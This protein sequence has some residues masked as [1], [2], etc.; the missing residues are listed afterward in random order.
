[1]SGEYPNKKIRVGVLFGGR[2]GEHEVSITSAASVIDALDPGEFEITAIGIT[3]FG[4]I[5]VLRS[6]GFHPP[7]EP[8]TCASR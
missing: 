2:S 6:P 8:A 1:M 3:L 7:C 5:I 4:L